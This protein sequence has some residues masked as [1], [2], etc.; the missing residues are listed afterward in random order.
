LRIIIEG[1]IQGIGF[2]P[3]IYRTAIKNNISGFIRNNED[4]SI[5]IAAKGIKSDIDIFLNE[6]YHNKPFLAQYTNVKIEKLTN[7]DQDLL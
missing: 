1:T 7:K 4:G 5:E 3:F 2:R 6:I